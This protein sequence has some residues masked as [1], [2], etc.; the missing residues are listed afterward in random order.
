MSDATDKKK[1]GEKEGSY[2]W[3]IFYIEWLR[4]NLL[5]INI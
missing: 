4:K 2:A 3:F 5:I 1:D